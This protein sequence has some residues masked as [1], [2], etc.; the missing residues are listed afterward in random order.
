MRLWHY[1]LLPYLDDFHI[2]SQWRELLAIKGAIDKN[3]T[4][5]HRLVNKV[6]D[7]PITDFKWYVSLVTSELNRRNI[8]Y[9]SKKRLEVYNWHS[10]KFACPN[11]K[12]SNDNHPYMDWH[13]DTYLRQ[14]I[15]NLEEKAICN[16]VSKHAW[17]KI[18]DKFHDKFVL[19][20]YGD[21][22]FDSA[23]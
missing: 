18:Y 16:I 5:N 21:S 13:N 6:L 22:S 4:P 19:W 14:C 15:Y 3:G 2:V 17:N 8:R 9:D 1:K 23:Y 11:Y 10:D 7:Y 12:W 20:K